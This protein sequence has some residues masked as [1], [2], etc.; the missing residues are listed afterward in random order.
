[1]MAVKI[2]SLAALLAGV[3]LVVAKECTVVHTD[4]QDDSPAILSAFQECAQD[5]VITFEAKNYSAYTPM[6][7]SNLST[8]VSRSM[9]GRAK[10]LV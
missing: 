1:M 7:L 5:S 3:T 9:S 8:S 2:R 6:T 10:H 4:G